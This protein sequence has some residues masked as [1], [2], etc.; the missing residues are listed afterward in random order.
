[1]VSYDMFGPEKI[2]S[3]IETNGTERN[4]VKHLR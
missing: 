4:I 2:V 1:M 3:K